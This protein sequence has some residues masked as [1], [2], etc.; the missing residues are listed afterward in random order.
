MRGTD[1]K[2]ETAR[3]K[4]LHSLEI[5]DTPS[6]RTFDRIVRMTSRVFG[7]PIAAISLVDEF[8]QW[9]KANCG[10]AGYKEDFRDVSFCTRTILSDE[11]MVVSDASQDPKF[12]HFPLVSGATKVRFY[13]GAPL[14]TADGHRLG[15]LCVMDHRPRAFSTAE[16]QILAEL[17]ALVVDEF[18]LRQ[19]A[20][21]LH[22]EV[23]GRKRDGR[24][25]AKQHRLLQT[26]SASLADGIREQTAQRP[27]TEEARRA[28]EE[29]FRHLVEQ[30]GEAF[31]VLDL[32]GYIVN[33]NQAACASLGYQREELLGLSLAMVETTFDPVETL[34][35]WRDWKAGHARSTRGIHRRKGGTTFPVEATVSTIQ[36]DGSRYM[37]ALVRDMTEQHRAETALQQAKEEA[38]KA[39][40]AKSEFL[41]RMSHELRTP[42][43]A[44]LGFGQILL[45]QAANAAQAD[46][47]TQV[48]NAGNHLLGLINEVL[49][50]ARIEAGQ[51]RLSVEPIRVANLVAETL[52]LIRPQV[53]ERGI[54]ME[55]SLA[56]CADCYLLADRQRCKQVLLN[57]LSNAVKYSLRAGCVRVGC[58][59]R[60]PREL[61]I[62]VSDA[63]PGIAI[64]QR[65]RLFVAFE[66]LGAE[67]SGVPGT[68]LGLTLSKHLVEAMGGSI[69]VKS[70]PGEGSTF[71]LQLPRSPGAAPSGHA[72][73][74]P[75]A[76]LRL[77]AGPGPAEAGP[78]RREDC[79]VLYIE[80]NASNLSL[81]EHLFSRLPQVRLLTARTG[82]EGLKLA[83]RE[84]PQLVLLDLHL[85]DMP[86]REVL[87]QLRSGR[88]TRAI[89]VVA[90][91]ADATP[92][93]VAR[94][95]K[96]GAHAYLTKP[97][98][99]DTFY[100]L[101][102]SLGLHQETGAPPAGLAL[103]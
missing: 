30:A 34:P 6:E 56:G 33:V 55:V 11:V 9:D 67:R 64:N 84:R 42:L 10:L 62:S 31:F 89:P 73:L 45:A 4:K 14:R 26:L 88:R 47:A 96:D 94:L 48:V 41:S 5:L 35:R 53:C 20:G 57:L 2:R 68:G 16:G 28:S 8:R 97:L 19:V 50:I 46:C 92:G 66:R 22:T 51:V 37:L 82:G 72:P 23:N 60:R 43:N 21:R 86:G 59:L 15:A 80:D 85:P 40:A 18:T 44:I 98:N 74:L 100:Q 76:T 61:R 7:V 71:W 54:T 13:A 1:H 81:I 87:A 93:S 90:V 70:V 27:R 52:D 95:I 65:A 91:S 29:R 83:R 25:L 17:A 75:L 103:N 49:D 78:G 58:E 99:I 63:G 69:G 32:D 36:T 79:T 77:G 12:A 102:P 38:E 39:N 24:A 101:L 3:L